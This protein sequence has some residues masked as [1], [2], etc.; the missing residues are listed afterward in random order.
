MI[1]MEKI[2]LYDFRKNSYY[3]F[4]EKQNKNCFENSFSIVLFSNFSS[5]IFG[6]NFRK[7]LFE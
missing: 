5:N 7:K 3:D 1:F 2:F 6:T 4:F